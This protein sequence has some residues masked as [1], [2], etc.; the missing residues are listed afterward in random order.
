MDE[1]YEALVLDILQRLMAEDTVNPPGNEMRGAQ[2]LKQIFEAE[3]IP[4]EIQDLGGNR[5]N[6]IAEI[7]EGEPLL[8]FSGHI[9]VVPCI[10][11]WNYLP[12]HATIE[13]DYV[14]GRGA[15]DMKGGVAAMCAAAITLYREHVDMKGKLRLTFVADEEHTNFGMKNYLANYKPAKYAVLG[16]PTNLHV[17]IAHRGVARF[18]ID[19]KGQAS[20]SALR[21]TGKNAVTKAAEA[22]LAIDKINEKMLEVKH[23]TLPSPSLVVTQVQGYEKDNVIPGTVRLLTDYRILPGVTE[24]EARK[25]I[26]EELEQSGIKDYDMQTRVYLQGGEIAPEEPFVGVCCSAAAKEN[27]RDEKPMPF[28][29]SCEQCFLVDAGVKT[30]VLGPGSLEQAHTVNEFV[31]RCQLLR[32]VKIYRDIALEILK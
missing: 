4:C 16:E 28:G 20:H 14:Y 15:C 19:L 17:A 2:C 31:E 22:I 7:G 1:K 29:A 11:E 24:E 21:M 12:L 25:T 10:G 30:V 3:G 18:Y 32:A 13:K 5:A 27:A 26:C 8:E 23:H 9:D 6:F